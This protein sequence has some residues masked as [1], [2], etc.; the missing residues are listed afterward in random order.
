M[1]RR[2]SRKRRKS[3]ASTSHAPAAQTE[4]VTQ[5]MAE[6]Y[7]YVITD[8]R[9]MALVAGALVLGLVILSFVL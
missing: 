2:R 6:D 1:A 9:R 5:S 3:S 8:L 7:S 4:E